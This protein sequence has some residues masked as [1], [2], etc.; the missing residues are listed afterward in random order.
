M[1]E[2]RG[3][4]GKTAGGG[5]VDLAGEELE[6]GGDLTSG[7][8]LSTAGERERGETER[9]ACRSWASGAIWVAWGT[10]GRKKDDG[11]AGKEEGKLG[12]G[13]KG[14]GWRVGEG[15]IF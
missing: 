13:A 4:R 5:V 6:V 2:R 10:A 3:R 12:L 7:V 9:A 8:G 15:F 11:P 14:K 1:R